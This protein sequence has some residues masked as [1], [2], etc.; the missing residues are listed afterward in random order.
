MCKTIYW[1]Y[2]C[3]GC[4]GLLSYE[5]T[6]EYCD[7]PG[8]LEQGCVLTGEVKVRRWAA[9]CCTK[10]EDERLKKLEEQAK[11]SGTS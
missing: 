6:E 1:N 9:S 5:Q 2:R 3:A 4:Y 7:V 10:C 11:K 8:Q